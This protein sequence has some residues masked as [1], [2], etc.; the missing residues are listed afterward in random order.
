MAVR[1]QSGSGRIAGINYSVRLFVNDIPLPSSR[2][3]GCS[4]RL[5]RGHKE[6]DPM[7]LLMTEDKLQ[8]IGKI[9]ILDRFLMCLLVAERSKRRE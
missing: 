4:K 7:D 3:I 5:A 1:R 2:R 6:A 8:T 9:P